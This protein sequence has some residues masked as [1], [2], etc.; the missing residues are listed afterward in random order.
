MK[1]I[2]ELLE[3]FK[4]IDNVFILACG[5][6]LK[7]FSNKICKNNDV[8]ISLNSSVLYC[9][10]SINFI[11]CRRFYQKYKKSIPKEKS[12]IIPR[13]LQNEIK[14][15]T[16]FIY[17]PT[18]NSEIINKTN[19]LLAGYS[20]LIP[21]LNFAL[22][23]NP[24]KILLYGV[25]LNDFSHWDGHGTTKKRFPCASKICS[26]VQFLK[27]Y[28]NYDQIFCNFEKS[29]LVYHGIIEHFN[30]SEVF[31]FKKRTKYYQDIIEG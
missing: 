14:N 7:E 31:D 13:N 12:I 20:V 24:N 19:S 4:N 29:K 30:H 15:E 23:I 26:Q 27:S 9:N 5:E 6:S 10:S 2:T 8:V 25:E 11:A 18:N 28:F 3:K 21:A 1:T 17:N 16:K 22:R